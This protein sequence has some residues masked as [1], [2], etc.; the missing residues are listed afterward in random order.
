MTTHRAVWVGPL[1]DHPSRSHLSRYEAWEIREVRSY[2]STEQVV[3]AKVGG[4]GFSSS[5]IA[6]LFQFF[7]PVVI[8]VP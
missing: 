5:P 3:L 7:R 2:G 8:E 1:F 6:D 4:G